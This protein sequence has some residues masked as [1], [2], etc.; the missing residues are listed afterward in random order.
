MLEL[1]PG[2]AEAHRKAGEGIG[3]MKGAHLFL[4]GDQAKHLAEGAIGAGIEAKNVRV[5]RNH[6]EVLDRLGQILEEGDWILVKGSRR[7]QME[8]IIQGLVEKIGRL[9]E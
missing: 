8:R 9:E 5:A 3:E 6:Q 4:L 2:S 1:G 7:M